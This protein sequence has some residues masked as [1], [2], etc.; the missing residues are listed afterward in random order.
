MK[1]LLG[2]YVDV[3]TASALR[4]MSSEVDASI[5]ELGDLCLRYAL[6]RMP[7]DTLRQWAQGLTNTRGRLGGGMT[8]HEKAAWGA[9]NE[10]CEKDGAYR[11]DH[12]DIAQKAGLTPKEAYLALRSLERR[13]ILKGQV[14][15]EE[16]DRWGRPV[17]SYWFDPKRET[18]SIAQRARASDAT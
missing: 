4:E 14:W 2:L 7:K 8:K 1:T 9:Y 3:E 17:K 12:Q 15:G 16:V 10:I 18:A 5:S 11:L 13:G 6:E